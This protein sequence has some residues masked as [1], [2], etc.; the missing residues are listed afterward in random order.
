MVLVLAACGGHAHVVTDA[1]PDVAPP[2]APAPVDFTETYETSTLDVGGWILT[3]NPQRIRTIEP[4]GGDPDGFLYGE[5]S[6]AVPA[7][8][9]ASTRY[10]PGVGDA[11]KHDS[12]FVGDFDAADITTL[13]ADL[14]VLQAGNWSSNRTI[15][16]HVARWDATAGAVGLEAFYSLP[17]IAA[18]PSGWNH[19]S[20]ALPARS[21][22]IPAGWQLQRGDGTAGSDADWTALM[23]QVDLVEL[24]Y[25]RPGYLYPSMGLWDLGIDNIHIS[26]LH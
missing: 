4:T 21:P 20:F 9:T 5:V 11:F 24:V 26:A 3:T 22:S 6:V 12:V 7:W 18:P 2:D 14:D 23:H 25:G 13:A 19:Y 10:Q 1:Q 8:S 17:D 16:L 15:T